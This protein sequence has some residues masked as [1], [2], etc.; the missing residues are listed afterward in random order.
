MIKKRNLIAAALLITVIIACGGRK[1]G[2]GENSGFTLPSISGEQVGFADYKGKVVVLDFF[3]TW[4]GPCRSEIPHLVDIY[5]RNKD[6]G[7]VILGI[8]LEDEAT[9]TNFRDEN[10][11]TYPILLGNREVFNQ[12][13]VSPIPHTIFFDKKG[14][15]RKV[16]IGFAP[17]LIPEFESLIETM[18]NE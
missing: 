12:Y 4:C 7:F 5:N 18:L 11:I 16:Q 2:S 6:R 15:Q 17:Q 9:L 10:N 3:A 13:N 1:N 14:K 8:S